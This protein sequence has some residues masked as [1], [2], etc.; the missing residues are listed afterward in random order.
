MWCSFVLAEYREFNPGYSKITVFTDPEG[1]L[2]KPTV[3]CTGNNCLSNAGGEPLC[4]EMCPTGTLIYTDADDLN[5]KR[6]ELEEKKGEQPLFKLIVPWKYPY[7]W[8]E[9]PGT[10]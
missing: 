4:V 10:E 5:E 3:D 2:N 7:P 8:R 1:K 6:A 9:W